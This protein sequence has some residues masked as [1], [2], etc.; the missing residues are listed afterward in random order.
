MYIHA[1]IQVLYVLCILG[2][3][4]RC[5]AHSQVASLALGT[6]KFDNHKAIE[7]F[8]VWL[9]KRDGRELPPN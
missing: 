4:A 2:S 9:H 3:N 7:D 5:F 8:Y 6:F 1:P